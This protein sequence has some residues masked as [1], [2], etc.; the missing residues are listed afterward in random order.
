MN[1][2]A[3]FHN[4]LTPMQLEDALV[5]PQT[6]T[7]S[8]GTDLIQVYVVSNHPQGAKVI[9]PANLLNAAL[10][11]LPTSGAG[12]PDGAFFFD[13]NVLTKKTS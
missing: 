9:T 6:T 1:A 4:P 8:S 13:S 3:V 7:V 10:T 12:L 5:A 2:G 11:A